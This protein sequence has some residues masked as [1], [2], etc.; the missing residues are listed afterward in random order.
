LDDL[1]LNQQAW[2]VLTY[3][4][5]D[6]TE[7]LSIGHKGML[8]TLKIFVKQANGLPVEDCSHQKDFDD[9]TS[10]EVCMIATER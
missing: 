8:R 3:Q 1:S 9:F 5:D 4:L 10:S 6:G 7:P 2:D